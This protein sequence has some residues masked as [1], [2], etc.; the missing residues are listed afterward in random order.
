MD[1][2]GEPRRYFCDPVIDKTEIERKLLETEI[3]QRTLTGE[4]QHI[5]RCLN[6]EIICWNRQAA[7]TFERGGDSVNFDDT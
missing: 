1:V 4:F 7:R 6:V 2:V 3:R 5:E